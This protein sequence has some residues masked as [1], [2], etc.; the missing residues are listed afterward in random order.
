[1][2]FLNFKRYLLINPDYNST[3][4]IDALQF[5]G[6][7]FTVAGK[8]A[9]YQCG[10]YSIAGLGQSGDPITRIFAT[11]PLHYSISITFNIFVVDQSAPTRN[12]LFVIILDNIIL[13]ASYITT[14]GVS[15][16]CGATDL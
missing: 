4:D 5:P 15:D 9:T 7:L 3:Y 1:L 16:L 6:S 11:L 2:H 8:P 13:E 10:I 12:N 14:E